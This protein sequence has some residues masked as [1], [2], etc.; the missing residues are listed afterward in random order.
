MTLHT[1]RKLDTLYA[2]TAPC[3]AAEAVSNEKP[4]TGELSLGIE[5][6]ILFPLTSGCVMV[7]DNF[8]GN[9]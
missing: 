6:P 1:F 8:G 7:P 2:E 5:Y 9:L 3:L 4:M